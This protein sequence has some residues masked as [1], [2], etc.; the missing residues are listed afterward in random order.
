MSK[1]TTWCAARR[2]R[3]IEQEIRR[4]RRAMRDEARAIKVLEGQ[5]RGLRLYA[6]WSAAPKQ[7]E[8]HRVVLLGPDHQP[9]AS[10]QPM[11]K[12]VA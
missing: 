5:A 4:R 11:R 10:W 12:G 2:A 9:M 1:L 7:E 3:R 6:A 8:G